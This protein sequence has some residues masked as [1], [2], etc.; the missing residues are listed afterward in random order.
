MAF[1][2]A[3]SMYRSVAQSFDQII[4]SLDDPIVS[5]ENERFTI[6]GREIRFDSSSCEWRNIPKMRDTKVGFKT[7]KELLLNLQQHLEISASC[8]NG[9]LQWRI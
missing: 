9:S 6:F 4:Q 2:A 5:I 7:L 3:K 8:P 1:L